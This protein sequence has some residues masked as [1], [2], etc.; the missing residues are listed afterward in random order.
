MHHDGDKDLRGSGFAAEAIYDHRY[1]VA[2][3][4]DNSLSPPA[5]V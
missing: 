3:V 5:W 4:I 2:G 1:C